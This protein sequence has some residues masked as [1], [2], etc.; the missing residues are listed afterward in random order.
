MLLVHHSQLVT[1]LAKPESKERLRFQ[2]GKS[3]KNQLL[4]FYQIKRVV[5]TSP[6]PR[7]N[8]DFMLALKNEN[9]SKYTGFS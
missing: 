5:P 7:G 9:V 1:V 4:F 8:A 3:W 6:L 2:I